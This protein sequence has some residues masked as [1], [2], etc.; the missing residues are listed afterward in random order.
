MHYKQFHKKDNVLLSQIK[1]KTR[2]RQKLGNLRFFDKPDNTS[3]PKS[4]HDAKMWAI[5]SVEKHKNL[6]KT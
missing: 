6:I 2:K 4:S 3:L 1:Q 5:Q